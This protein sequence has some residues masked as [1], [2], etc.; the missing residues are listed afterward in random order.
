MPRSITL[1]I[2][3][4]CVLPGCT[5]QMNARDS[6]DQSLEVYKFCLSQHPADPSSCEEAH[7]IYENDLRAYKAL[8]QGDH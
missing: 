3:L 5:V 1:A 4:G 8:S 7:Q 2:L 6:V